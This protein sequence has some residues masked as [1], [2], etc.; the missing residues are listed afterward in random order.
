MIPDE[1]REIVHVF[2]VE[3]TIFH[4]FGV[5]PENRQ[6]YPPLV[7]GSESFKGGIYFKHI[8]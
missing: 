6:K 3:N 2:T 8:P 5:N 4:H 7:D 1:G